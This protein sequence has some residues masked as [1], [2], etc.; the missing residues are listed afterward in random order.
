MTD[1]AP[2]IVV[3]PPARLTEMFQL[4]AAVWVAEG[5]DPG[6]FPSGEWRDDRD[7]S[8]LH[9][10]AVHAD[11]IVATASLSMHAT[12]ADVEEGDVYV[13]AGLFSPGPVAAPA[14]VTVAADFR[15]CG[16]AQ[17]LLD[18][19][20]AAALEA[21]ATLSVRQASPAMRRL[22]ERR[23]WQEHGP[24]PWDARFPGTQF[25]VMS[26]RRKT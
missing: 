20:D 26:L 3:C 23:G 9:W 19:Q 21:G 17:S 8:R 6:A 12:L 2:R 24:G 4:R 13:R 18:V 25:T 22:L 7:A 15:G 5:A 14:R 16:L 11:R 1:Q 10:I